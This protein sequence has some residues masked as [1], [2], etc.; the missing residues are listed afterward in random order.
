MTTRSNLAIRSAAVTAGLILPVI[1]AAHSNGVSW[2][3]PSGTLLILGPLLAGTLL[4]IAGLARRAAKTGT[5]LAQHSGRQAACFGLGVALLAT[6]LTGPLDAWAELS[7][8]AHMAQHMV[9]IALAPPLLLLGRPGAAWLRAL[10]QAWRAA[11]VSPQRWPGAPTARRWARSIAATALLQG[12]VLWGWHAPA[13]FEMALRHDAVHWLEHITLL[14]TGMLFW[15]A[16]LRAHGVM[17]GWGL[18]WMLG[19]VI[20]SGM[21]GA[22][23]TFAPRPLYAI[24]AERNGVANVLADQQLA[25]LIMW[26]PMGTIYLLAALAFAARSLRDRESQSTYK[27]I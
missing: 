2:S 8:S 14:A 6:A 3:T 7:F 13:A 9:L 4:Y 5:A 1:A 24:Y 16:L 27:S 15:R 25:G 21:L 11:A 22:L 18:G 20:H 17:L 10:P 19:T 12:A 23:I 26:V